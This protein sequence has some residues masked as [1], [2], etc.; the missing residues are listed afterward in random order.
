MKMKKAILLA[1]AL[2]LTVGVSAQSDYT[3]LD[4]VK[5]LTET[6]S[7]KVLGEKGYVLKKEARGA[8]HE[9]FFTKGKMFLGE[10]FEWHGRDDA[11]SLV[12]VTYV[13]NAIK[14]I[15]IVY[16]SEK[17]IEVSF[18][19]LKYTKP[20]AAG[21]SESGTDKVF[22]FTADQLDV[23]VEIPADHETTTFHIERRVPASGK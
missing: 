17:S 1:F 2:L 12:R 8:T 23:T 16:T 21:E 11:S 5:A 10:D 18:D 6:Q 7:L 20:T 13:D 22:K 14:S 9:L 3:Y 19:Q 4:A 15:D